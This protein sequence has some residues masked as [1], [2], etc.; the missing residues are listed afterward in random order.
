MEYKA[1]QPVYI[2]V[3]NFLQLELHLME[4]RPG[5]KP[6]VFLTELIQRW[7]AREAERQESRNNGPALRGIRWKSLFLPDGTILRTSHVDSSEFAKVNGDC[8]V[9]E[10]GAVLTPSLF[11]SRHANGRNAWRWVWLRFPGE[12]GW[13]RADNCRERSNAQPRKR[14]MTTAETSKTVQNY[15]TVRSIPVST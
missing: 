13:I 14:A 8:I 7:L 3:A 15:G 10:D 4:S 1:R 9:A 6:E 5:I 2:S 11:A 12:N